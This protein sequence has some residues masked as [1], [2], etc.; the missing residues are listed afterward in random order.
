MMDFID[1]IMRPQLLV[2][3]VGGDRGLR[4]RSDDRHADAGA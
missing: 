3:A 1:L 4:D 2:M